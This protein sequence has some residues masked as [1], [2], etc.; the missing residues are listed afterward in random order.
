MEIYKDNPDV[1]YIELFNIEAY[2][3]RMIECSEDILSYYVEL[4]DAVARLKSMRFD[5]VLN[6][7]HD[8]FCTFLAY[9]LV[10][11]EIKGMYLSAAKRLRILIN[12]FWFK[13]LRCTSNFRETASFNLTDIY[14]NAV[15]GDTTVRNL[16]FHTR[17]D[18]LLEAEQLLSLNRIDNK[19][20]YYI[21]FQLGTSSGSRR[22]PLEHF[23]A[24]GNMLHQ[25]KRVQVVL[26]GSPDEKEMGEKLAGLMEVK[27][28]DFIGR[29]D[30][31][32]L[33][34]ILKKCALLV[35]NDTGTMHLAEAVGTRCV[36]LFFESAN[37]FQTGP[38]GA[39]HII[40]SPELDCF[41]CPTTFQCDEKRCL[42]VI[43]VDT[44]YQLVRHKLDEN[45]A[46]TI[47]PPKGVR[48]YETRFAR[49][50]TWDAWPMARARLNKS[51]LARRIYRSMWLKYAQKAGEVFFEE[52]AGELQAA[53]TGELKAWAGCYVVEKQSLQGWLKDFSISLDMLEKKL[54]TGITLLEE[55]GKACSAVPFNK[56][57][58]TAKS[59]DVGLLDQ[60]IVQAGKS[61]I[62]LS[63]I[64]SLFELELEQIQDGNF[65]VMLTGWKQTYNSLRL[66]VD[67]LNKEIQTAGELLVKGHD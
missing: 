6:T 31:S 54:N 43:T 7:T 32:V 8:R 16:F 26:L 5:L 51:D 24:L 57:A 66:R 2:T 40:C 9:L 29:T 12:G 10:P 64:T 1:D 20:N 28:V 4:R 49:T 61:N 45:T 22:W 41:P 60:Q 59:D 23:A 47:H 44:V 36:A 53:L 14:K 21:G 33:A 58:V 52:R 37:P 50:G 25:D 63:Q 55:I 13:Y 3:N 34:A 27:P 67:L 19:R 42:D 46:K 35:T 65:F 17:A 15:G 56:D 48:I 11:P 62:W 18:S 38:Y 39:G 30:L